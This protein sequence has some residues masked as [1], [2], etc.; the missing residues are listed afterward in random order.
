MYRILVVLIIMLV[1]SSCDEGTSISLEE[2][3]GIVDE[4]SQT[5]HDLNKEI[6]ESKEL[7]EEV[8]FAHEEQIDEIEKLSYENNSL[9]LEIE[10]HESNDEYM[11]SIEV[12]RMTEFEDGLAS[13]TS[14]QE[15]FFNLQTLF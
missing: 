13:A 5:N 7:L 11:R 12:D 2:H 9:S 4:L 3:Q 8:I 15:Y 1:L 14:H 6:E 10:S